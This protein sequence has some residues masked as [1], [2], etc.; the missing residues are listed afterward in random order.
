MME[1]LKLTLCLENDSILLN[2]AII[3]ALERPRQVQILINDDAKML[4]LRACTV[5]DQQ[6]VVISPE[7]V[8]QVEISGRSLLKRIRKLT[9]WQGDE[10]RI[11]Y[12]EYLPA[13]RA[14]RFNL[15]DAHTMQDGQPS[16]PIM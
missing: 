13:H 12:G 1:P 4:A 14:V 7:K 9:G 6:A 5:E 15:M 2:S 8:M 3:E 16:T 11:L 10:P